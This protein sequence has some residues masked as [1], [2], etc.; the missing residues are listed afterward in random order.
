MMADSKWEVPMMLSA[1]L[2]GASNPNG[3]SVGIAIDLPSYWA[4]H[5]RRLCVQNGD[6]NH[7]EHA[8]LFYFLLDALKLGCKNVAAYSDSEVVVTQM[9]CVYRWAGQHARIL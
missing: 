6:P 3:S 4:D 2:D 8:A 5:S 7:V 1:Y 9:R